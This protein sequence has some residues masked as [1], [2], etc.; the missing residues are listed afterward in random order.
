MFFEE[1]EYNKQFMDLANAKTFGYEGI[2]R[3]IPQRPPFLMIDKV[4]DLDLE[5]D[6][7]ICVK[8]IS[9]N[10]PWFAG[11]FP[12]KPVMP[13]VLMLE[14]MAQAASILGRFLAKKE[15]ILM[16]AGID[17]VKFL[18]IAQPGD[19][20]IIECKIIKSRDP[21]MVGEC[22]ISVDGKDIMTATIKPFRK[23]I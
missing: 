3:L 8:N 18:N 10:E 21:L 11:H 6:K 23:D 17:D 19:Q 13:G 20:L 2:Y 7:V 4:L 15:G 9:S 14:A 22:K 5:N 16:F 1:N 12:G